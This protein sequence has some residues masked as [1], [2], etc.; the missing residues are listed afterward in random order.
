MDWINGS[1]VIDAKVLEDVKQHALETYPGECCGFLFGPASEPLV[2]DS[3]QRE[4]NLADKYHA[5]DPE[6]FPRTSRTYFKIDELKAQKTFERSE[7]ERR[8]LK[9]IYHSHCDAGAYFSKEDASTFASEGNLLWPCS[10]LVVSV[11]KGRVAEQK[12]WV[13]QAGTNG[14]VESAITVR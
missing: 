5:L 3:L 8:P 7:H 13:H 1:L 4:K 2:V 14:F 10:F 9:V 11:Q 12:L 6:T